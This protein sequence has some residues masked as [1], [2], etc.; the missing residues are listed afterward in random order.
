MTIRRLRSSP[1][2][3]REQLD[4]LSLRFDEQAKVLIR[5]FVM[6]EREMRYLHQ[7]T[8][9]IET[10][11]KRFW[12]RSTTGRLLANATPAQ[13]HPADSVEIALLIAR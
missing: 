4:R 8:T 13:N 11:S 6:T 9:H 7:R 12:I 1:A 3:I 10:M 2:A 5:L